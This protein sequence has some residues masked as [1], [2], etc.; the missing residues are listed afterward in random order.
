MINPRLAPLITPLLALV[1][2]PAQAQSA[3]G[4]FELA[5]GQVKLAPA[6]SPKSPAVAQVGTDVAQDDTVTTLAKA[7]A[8][9]R[10]LDES[11][12]SMGENTRLRLTR[13][14]FDPDKGRD[15]DAILDGGLALF[16]ISKSISL[17]SQAFRVVTPFGAIHVRGTTFFVEVTET[18][19]VVTVLAGE[20]ELEGLAGA[21]VMIR[22]G[23][24]ASFDAAGAPSAP[25]PAPP[26]AEGTLSLRVLPSGP[27]ITLPALPVVQQALGLLPTQ[28]ITALLQGTTQ[29]LTRSLLGPQGALRAAS[30]PGSLGA[31]PGVIGALPLL[32]LDNTAATTRVTAT[33]VVVP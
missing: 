7:R 2:P 16:R 15:G 18:E 19:A 13:M 22:A 12:I 21:R 26:A 28:P 10:F 20:V 33:V 31:L 24:R 27:A 9:L 8:R 32:P 4:A 11:T 3:I 6:G 1:A 29:P 5:E 30:L 25:S 14:V 17:L 23:E